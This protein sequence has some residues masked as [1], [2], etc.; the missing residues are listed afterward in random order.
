MRNEVGDL[1]FT[2]TQKEE[3]KK[4]LLASRRRQTQQLGVGRISV[5]GNPLANT[6]SA[7][8]WGSGPSGPDLGPVSKSPRSS[9]FKPSEEA[10][11]TEMLDDDSVEKPDDV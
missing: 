5:D 2:W 1:L 7:R 8:Q 3:T 11:L 6:Q 9:P 10:E 4:R